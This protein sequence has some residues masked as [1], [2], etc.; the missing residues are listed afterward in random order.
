MPDILTAKALRENRAP[1]AKQ[2]KDMAELANAENRDFSAEE[3]ANW[4]KLN[5]DYDAL[6]ASISR[7]ERAER[8]ILD[9]EEP[10]E[11][12]H[13]P[14]RENFNGRERQED[15]DRSARERE[16]DEGPT[17]EDRALA[18]QAWLRSAADKELDDRHVKACVKVGVRPHS[19]NY[20]FNL[21]RDVG[22]MRG[23]FRDLSS[24][25]GPAGQYTVP[26]GFVNNLEMAMLAFGGMRQ[27]SE[28]MRTTSG[29]NMP[30]PT[31]NDT[32]N[33][34]VI[35]AENTAV[36]EQDVT[37][38]QV[39][40]YAH[41]YSSKMIQVPVE[42]LEDSAFDLA[43]EIGRML[44]ERLGRI[45]NRHFTVGTGAGQPEGI[46]PGSTLGVTAASATAIAADEILDLI[47]SV[48]PAY[49]PNAGFMCHDN[50]VLHIRK[51]KDGNGQYLWAS[52]L[53]AGQSDR[54]A[55]Y[56]LT[57]NQHMQSSVATATK[58]L[59]FGQLSKYKIRDVAG[60]RLIRLNE[61]FA[62]SDQVAF[63]SFSRHDGH[64]LDAGVAPVK[65][66]LQA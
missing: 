62:D 66:L 20:D 13:L 26:T 35:I 48:D 15:E 40:F 57:N 6:S 41:K 9:Q 29:N 21:R 11:E 16:R 56:P 50:I 24:V 38:G 4:E 33:E 23:E 59:I 2:I 7:A 65:H 28:I 27:V 36:S 52:G 46:V 34:G 5:K 14:G 22:K 10:A 39:I 8:V 37:F 42:L 54:L 45:T 55:G 12:R 63:L 30:W 17:E 1:L 51:L 43:S 60:V 25:S 3:Q 61:R 18:L 58:T 44:G 49:R 19:Q 47:H 64:L 32:S 53:N 31:T